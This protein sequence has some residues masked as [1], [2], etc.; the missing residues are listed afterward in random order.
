VPAELQ[1]NRIVSLTFLEGRFVEELVDGRCAS[2]FS[3]WGQGVAQS[4]LPAAMARNLPEIRNER[5]ETH[6]GR[7]ERS[8]TTE[9]RPAEPGQTTQQERWPT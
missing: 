2:I 8:A 3:V 9:K 4:R 5:S 1:A 7:D 6:Y